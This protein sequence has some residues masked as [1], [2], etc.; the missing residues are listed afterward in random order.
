MASG[1]PG[2]GG[3]CFAHDTSVYWS[4]GSQVL[5]APK[6]GGAS[7]VVL[8]AGGANSV[9]GFALDACNVYVAV[10]GTSYSLWGQGLPVEPSTSPEG[11][12]AP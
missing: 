10:A 5:R 2:G 1:L 9:T 3:G 12:S 7:E 4:S 6:S 8:D 11:D